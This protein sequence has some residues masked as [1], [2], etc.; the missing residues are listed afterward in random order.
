MTAVEVE[1]VQQIAGLLDTA[2]VAVY[3][4]SSPYAA[5]DT[6]VMF[7]EIPTEPDRCVAVNVYDSSDDPRYP[8][9]DVRVQFYMRGVPNNPLDVVDLAAG[10]F[11]TFQSL[12]DATLG[13]L[14][15]IDCKRLVVSD[16][17]VDANLRSERADSYQFRLDVPATAL[18]HY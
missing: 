8:R 3:K 14:H 6:A 12:Q 1:L 18:R 11:D 13:T 9:S 16:Q 10:V 2:G 17:G 5:S 7:G 4:P 15:L